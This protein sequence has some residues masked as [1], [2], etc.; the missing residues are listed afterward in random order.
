ME[1]DKQTTRFSK[2]EINLITLYHPAFSYTPP[3]NKTT[4]KRKKGYL[5]KRGSLYFYQ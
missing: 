3:S 4:L 1:P 5:K 2:H